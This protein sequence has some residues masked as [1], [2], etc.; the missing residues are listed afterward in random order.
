MQMKLSKEGLNLIKKWEG[1]RAMAYKCVP[2]ETYYTIG[3]GHY[4]AD[5]YRGMVITEDEAEALLLKD[6]DKFVAHVN[7]YQGIYNFN[8][9]EFDALVSFAYNIGNIRQLTQKGTR[10]KSEIPVYMPQ[11]CK[12]GGVVLK[13]LVNRRNDE[14]SLF[15]K[16]VDPNPKTLKDNNAIALEVIQ[17]KWGNGTARKERLTEAGYNYRTIQNIVNSMLKV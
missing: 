15:K 2:S 14:V 13:G 7:S 5:V 3:Y 6:C 12:A 10:S 9:N 11:Y 1:F 8:Q 17:G 4:G 16:P